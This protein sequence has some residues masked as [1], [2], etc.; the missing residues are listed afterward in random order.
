MP[1]VIQ[2]P[3]VTFA[4]ANADQE[5]QNTVQRLLLV[6]QMTAAGSAT[7]GSLVENIGSTA[8]PENALFG[9][10]SQLAEIVRSVKRVAPQVRVDAIPLDDAGGA[11]SRVMTLTITDSPTEDGSFTVT[12]GSE[13]QNKYT[14]SV[15]SGD[16]VTA[17][18]SGVAVAVNADTKSPFDAGNSAGVVTLTAVNGGEVANDLGVE[19]AS[20]LG[21]L[22]ATL[23][24]TTPGATDPTLTDILDVATDRYQGVVWPYSSSVSV[25]TTYL[26]DR[27]NPTN[28]VLDGVGFTTAVDSHA[29]HLT[30]LDSLNSESLVL[31]CD[32]EEGES[33]Y[34]GSAQNEPSY[35]KSAMFAAVR[36]LRLTPD[37]NIA[38][39]LTSSASLDNFGGVALASLPYFNTILPDLPLIKAGRGWTEIEI[40]QLIA[41]GG[42]VMGQNISGDTGL[43]GEVVTTYLTDAASNPDVT[44][45]FLNYVDTSSNVREYF[46]NN[47]KSRFGQSRLTE[48]AVS[49]GRDMANEVVIRAFSEKLYQDLAGTDFVLVQ[50][51][52]DAIQ[53]FKENLTVTL[54]LSVGK[55]TMTM[56]VPL[57]TQLRTFVATINITFSTT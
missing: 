48:G 24:E 33:L 36:A 32:K 13:V 25:L 41:A 1:T 55:V 8:A 9:I 19:M 21:G 7:D 27:F 15:S 44:F 40:E 6:G 30:A 17:V 38:R 50:D 39:F 45:T 31:F 4:L 34:I 29:N 12:A 5:V 53:F 57:V 3:S 28:A 10:D 22:A 2:Q 20:S 37:Q 16:T 46:F 49:R 14:I 43:V 42:S 26:D 47:F 54:D 56:L 18:A 11:T 52:E 51:G 35:S 23:S